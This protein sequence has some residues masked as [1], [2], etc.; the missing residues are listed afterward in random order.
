MDLVLLSG[1]H[2]SANLIRTAK[3]DE[4]DCCALFVDY[5]QPAAARELVAA[6]KITD[7]FGVPLIRRTMPTPATSGV[8]WLGRNLALIGVAMPVAL[9]HKCKRILIGCTDQDYERFPDCRQDFINSL[10]AAAEI[11]YNV[12]VVAPLTVRPSYIVKGTWSCY[13][14]GPRPCGECPSCK[15]E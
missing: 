9:E 3:K 4:Q 8:E 12:Q 1:G 11:G 6:V 13:G 10:N 7:Y 2:D 15:Q 14:P 5:G